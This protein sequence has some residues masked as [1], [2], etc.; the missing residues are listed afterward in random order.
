MKNTNK[1][2]LSNLVLS[3]GS[4]GH[5]Y[6]TAIFYIYIYLM[7]RLYKNRILHNRVTIYCKSKYILLIFRNKYL[8]KISNNRIEIC[9]SVKLQTT[10]LCHTDYC[11]IL[12][13]QSH[14]RHLFT[15]SYMCS[16]CF[17]SIV[18][19]FKQKY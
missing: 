4:Y 17:Y 10:C 13:F 12:L 1:K 3:S 11:D 18:Y 8:G 15:V 7:S 16:L 9:K 5:T 19:E 2:D 6:I 14:R